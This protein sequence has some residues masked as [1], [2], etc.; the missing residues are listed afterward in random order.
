M[1][2]K[3]V[4]WAVSRYRKDIYISVSV[5]KWGRTDVPGKTFVPIVSSRRQGY[6]GR[7]CLMA[8]DP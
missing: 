4:T 5:T 7:D 2:E 3:T 6:N 1:Q 8:P